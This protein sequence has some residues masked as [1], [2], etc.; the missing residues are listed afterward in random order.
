MPVTPD[1]IQK[2]TDGRDFYF[3]VI[4]RDASGLLYGTFY[5][6]KDVEGESLSEHVDGGTSRY[7]KNGVIYQAICANCNTIPSIRCY[8]QH[9]WC[10]VCNSEWFAGFRWL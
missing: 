1:A 10:S 2:T 5:G 9:P 4:K 6:Q 7:D 8:Q 3:I